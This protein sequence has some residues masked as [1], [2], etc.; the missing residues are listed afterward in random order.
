[1]QLPLSSWVV[2]ALLPLVM[3][4]VGLVTARMT[5]LRTLARMP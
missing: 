2:L 5:V 1:L 4:L 3:G